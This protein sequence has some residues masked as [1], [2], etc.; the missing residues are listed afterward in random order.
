MRNSMAPGWSTV[1]LGSVASV[2]TGGTPSRAC[3]EFWGGPHAWMASGEVKQRQVRST[4]ETITDAGLRSSNAKLL[5]PGTVVVA[6]NGQGKTRGTAARLAIRAACNQSIAAITAK[7]GASSGFLFHNLDNRYEELRN[8]TGDDSRTGL[9]LRLFR[10]LPILLPPP[11][12]QT[13]IASKLDA[14]DEA[15]ERTEDVIAATENVRKAL[16]QELLTRG[17]PGWHSEWTTVPGIGTIPECWEVV[18]LGEVLSKVQYG[19]NL[20]L[21]D[22]PVGIPVL[23]MGNLQD[24]RIDWSSL[25]WSGDAGDELAGLAVEAG[26]ILFNR[27][28]SIDLVGKVS[29]VGS[30]PPQASF[31]SYIVRLQTK[32]NRVDPY[33]LNALLNTPDAQERIRRMATKGAS[34]ANVN[35]TNLQTLTIPLPPPNEQSAMV[36]AV[37]ACEERETQD[38]QLLTRLRAIKRE[39]AS[40]LLSGRLLV[41]TTEDL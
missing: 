15:I 4:A 7:D 29:L 28:N 41:P 3:P 40:A 5:E 22:E 23:R 19:T 24:G 8:L 32:P 20:S 14:I 25:K 10:T 6:M 33:W 39:T 26:D 34:Q 11:E 12:L 13:E 9:N 35:P 21:V 27:T 38:R 30:E 1:L 37:Q 2:E 17:I 16:L 18:K 36:S 31:A